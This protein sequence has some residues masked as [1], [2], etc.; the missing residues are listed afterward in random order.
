MP[1][2]VGWVGKDRPLS[3]SRPWDGVAYPPP[4]KLFANKQIIAFAD[5]SHWKII[6]YASCKCEILHKVL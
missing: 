2:K 4:N 5:V 3:K 1:K 6:G